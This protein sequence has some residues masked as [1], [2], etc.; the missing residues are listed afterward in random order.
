MPRRFTLAG[1]LLWVTFVALVLAIVVPPLRHAWR[2]HFWADEVVDL[3]AS[4]DG[5]TFAALL[6][7]GRV[8]VWN[9]KERPIAALH[10][11]GTYAGNL[12]LSH[13]GRLAAV[14]PA[15][16]RDFGAVPV[17]GTVQIWDIAADKVQR[18]LPMRAGALW[19]SPVDD[20]LLVLVGR[21]KGYE[22]YSARGEEPPREFPAGF[23][24]AF[25]PDGQKLAVGT[26]ADKILIYDVADAR[27]ERELIAGG[28]ETTGYGPLAW[29]PDGRAIA[30]RAVP[31]GSQDSRQRVER[32]ELSTGH[33]ERM[34]TSVPLA[35][36][37]SLRDIDGYTLDWLPDSRHLLLTD[38]LWGRQVLDSTTGEW[39]SI[40]DRG[41]M[42]R[43]A[44]GLRG[45]TLIAATPDVIELWDAATLRPRR[46]LYE[47]PLPPNLWPA[48]VGLVLWLSI[49]AVHRVRRHSRVRPADDR[50]IPPSFGSTVFAASN[51]TGL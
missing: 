20:S 28:E 40:D 26:D 42:V 48:I 25:S 18:T 50:D 29:S 39:H 46:R 15:D 17:R 33:V 31:M 44:A 32:W 6:G 27:L 38:S 21:P 2:E 13:D 11:L 35:G 3:A 4:A 47:G 37:F 22:L 19:F 9:D 51:D 8:L 34:S 36:E 1:L 14:S 45:D 24:T 43:F 12:A 5:S 30:A 41:P 10:T 16:P 23:G 7:D 49:F